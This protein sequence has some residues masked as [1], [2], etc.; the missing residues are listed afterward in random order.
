MTVNGLKLTVDYCG[1]IA[2]NTDEHWE[3]TVIIR[4]ASVEAVHSRYFVCLPVAYHQYLSGLHVHSFMN[5]T[6]WHDN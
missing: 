4:P 6:I 2:E 3:N 5:S 1:K